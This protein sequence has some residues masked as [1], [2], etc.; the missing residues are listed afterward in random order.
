VQNFGSFYA[1]IGL[2][3]E[4][5]MTVPIYCSGFL[6]FSGQKCHL[7]NEPFN[8]QKNVLNK[9]ILDFSSG[10]KPTLKSDTEK[11]YYPHYSHSVVTL[12]RN[13]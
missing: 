2:F 9:L 8:I 3:E 1:H 6:L 7:Q 11:L 4:K 13:V 12:H 10:Y 5:K